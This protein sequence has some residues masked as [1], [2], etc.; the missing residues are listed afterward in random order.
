MRSLAVILSIT[1]LLSFSASV[2]AEPGP[3][4]TDAADPSGAGVS[5]ADLAYD[6]WYLDTVEGRPAGYSRTWMTVEDDHIVSGYLEVGVEKHGGEMS[7]TRTRVRWTESREHRPIAIEVQQS[8]GSDTVTKT[9]RFTENGITL[10]SEQNGR[11]IERTLPPIDGH[12]LTPSLQQALI[13]PSLLPEPPARLQEQMQRINRRGELPRGFAFDVVDPLVGM[14]PF[15][16]QYRQAAD[17]P[18]PY[19][20]ADGTEVSVTPWTITYAAFP[21]FEHRV[22]VDDAGRRV[23][24]AYE[25]DGMSF[26]SQLADEKVSGTVFDPPEMSGLS[27]VVP[28][29]PIRHAFLQRVIVYEL[30][31]E[32]GDSDAI[33]VATAQQ[34]VQRLGR[35]H[36][37]VTVDLNAKP[38]TPAS[39]RPEPK[40]LANS[41]MIDHEDEAVHA[42]AMKAIAK[43]G[44]APDDEA[45]AKACK[46][47]VTRHV[48][49]ASLAVGDATASEVARTR[50]GDCTECSV[51]LAALLRVHGIPSRCVNG[52]VY[53]EDDFAGQSDVFVYHQ[54]TQAWIGSDANNPAEGYWLDLD[55][56]MWR[57]SAGHIALGVSAMGDEDQQDLVEI[58]PLQQNLKIKVIETRRK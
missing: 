34:T 8:N 26:A 25:I 33:P 57:Y 2:R 55:S 54:W 51:L 24:Y 58:V 40:H 45:I 37:R 7:Q 11:T 12:F 3:A 1:A 29:K 41:I 4:A 16:T 5:S 47:L 9:Y 6:H 39:D 46:R 15:R 13:K 36:A 53:S 17:K 19:A 42:L 32:S 35:G 38:D 23:G 14:K 18:E 52:L 20:L 43:L 31:Y 44:D 27:V 48:N 10:T 21:G 22:Y 28:D 30:Q 49:G 50:E 56:A